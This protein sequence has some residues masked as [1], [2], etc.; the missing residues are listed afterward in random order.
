MGKSQYKHIAHNKRAQE[1]TED[2]C[3]QEGNRTKFLLNPD[4]MLVFGASQAFTVV[5]NGWV[6]RGCNQWSVYI[7]MKLL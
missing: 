4:V 6:S 2:T 3:Q 1:R 5:L 7:I